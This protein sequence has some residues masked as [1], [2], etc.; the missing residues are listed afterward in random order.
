MSVSNLRRSDSADGHTTDNTLELYG[1]NIWQCTRIPEVKGHARR[2]K[3]LPL[4]SQGRVFLLGVRL[5]SPTQHLAI[6]HEWEQDFSLTRPLAPGSESSSCRTFS[7]WKFYLGLC[8]M[9]IMILINRSTNATILV[10]Q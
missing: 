10:D 6:I 7:P 5:V 9:R 4:N 2:F 1:S 8:S 3:M